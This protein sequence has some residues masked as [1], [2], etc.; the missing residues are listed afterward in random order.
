MSVRG[1]LGCTVGLLLA[2]TAVGQQKNGVVQKPA[3]RGLKG[4]YYDGTN[5]QRKVFT[6]TDAQI[7]FDWEWGGSPGPGIGHSYYS[8]RWTGKL[9]APTTGVYKFGAMV[10]DGIRLWVNGKKVIDVWSLNDSKTFQGEI[11]LKA[12]QY[13]DLRVDYFND[14]HGGSI[15]LVWMPP[16]QTAYT[17]PDAGSYFPPTYQPPKPVV[18]KVVAK[19]VKPKPR[20]VVAQE[21]PVSPR[22]EPTVA[23]VVAPTRAPEPFENL[24]TGDKLVLNHVFFEQS[25]YRLLPES[26]AELDRLARALV[27]HPTLRIEIGG[28]TDN[29]G[30]PRLNLA[31]SENRAKVIETYLI[32][33]GIQ[34]ERIETKGYGGTRPLTDN[35]TEVNRAK[36]RRV[37]FF[38]K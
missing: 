18:A 22:K 3:G 12:G 21:P 27:Q 8:I 31:L 37:E 25:E 30:D 13:Y 20:P 23:S 10:D 33:K 4:E 26:Y 19:P 15:R 28:H 9:Y 36:N 38:V 14:R 2:Q 34:S 17:V 11:S 16:K 5:F 29:V 24:K 35:T 6:R 1:I 32:R 7:D